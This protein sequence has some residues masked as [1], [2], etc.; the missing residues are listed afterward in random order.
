MP[1]ARRLLMS[2]SFALP[3]LFAALASF[4]LL[5]EQG[6]QV[7]LT[8]L[9]LIAGLLLVAATEE[10]IGG[11]HVAANDSRLSAISIVADFVLFALVSSTFEARADHQSRCS[12]GKEASLVLAQF[13]GELKLQTLK[14][15]RNLWGRQDAK[16]HSQD[17][18]S[19]LPELLHRHVAI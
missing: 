4:F 7:Q 15:R 11:A 8:V 1:R 17:I 13:T 12:I 2:A 16:G 10:I 18:C 3:I 6:P 14:G 5:R 9:A 19:L